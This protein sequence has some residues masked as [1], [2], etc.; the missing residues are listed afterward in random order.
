MGKAFDAFVQFEQ[1]IFPGNSD[2]SENWD[3]IA[4]SKKQIFQ[5]PSTDDENQVPKKCG[6]KLLQWL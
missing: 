4:S 5:W 1:N 2:N 6:E 3:K